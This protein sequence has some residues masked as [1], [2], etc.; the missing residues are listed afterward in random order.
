MLGQCY[1]Y[2]ICDEKYNDDSTFEFLSHGLDIYKYQIWRRNRQ[3]SILSRP[4]DST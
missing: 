4:V 3:T 1:I 2:K